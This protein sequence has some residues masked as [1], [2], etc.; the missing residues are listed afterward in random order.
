[1][2]YKELPFNAALRQDGRNNMATGPDF[3]AVKLIMLYESVQRKS[4]SC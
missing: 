2:L 1:M 3:V 4:M